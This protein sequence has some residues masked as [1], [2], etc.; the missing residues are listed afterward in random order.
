MLALKEDLFA[1]ERA[2]V[3]SQASRY[4]KNTMLSPQGIF[5]VGV[6]LGL[7]ES[8][9]HYVFVSLFVHKVSL[10][11]ASACCVTTLAY[12]CERKPVRMTTAVDM[13]YGNNTY[14]HRNVWE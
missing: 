6:L 14:I 7:S 10:D 4:S 11:V 12:S 8:L 9:T 2:E 5:E 13:A 1:D 3:I